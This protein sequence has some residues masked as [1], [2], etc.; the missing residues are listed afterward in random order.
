MSGTELDFNLTF[1]CTRLAQLHAQLPQEVRSRQRG[2]ASAGQR[3]PSPAQR[4]C[5][6]QLAAAAPAG[7]NAAAGA[8]N[9]KQMSHVCTPRCPGSNPAP[10]PAALPQEQ[11]RFRCIWQE[12]E[13]WEPYLDLYLG[14]V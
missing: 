3:L 10:P 9:L 14:A 8:V 2:R 1:D 7:F 4:P 6:R 5:A 13:P 12:G 11:A